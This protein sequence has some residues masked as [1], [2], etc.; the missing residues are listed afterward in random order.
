MNSDTLADYHMR[1]F[2]V[3][4]FLRRQIRASYRMILPRPRR[5]MT[6]LPSFDRPSIACI[7]L[8]EIKV[9]EDDLSSRSTDARFLP[10]GFRTPR[11]VSVEAPCHLRQGLSS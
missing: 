1:D 8:P 7:S 9:R 4:D 2:I 3:L 6:S 11:A 5:S 10:N